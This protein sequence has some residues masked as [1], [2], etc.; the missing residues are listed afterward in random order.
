MFSKVFGSYL[1]SRRVIS[2]KD[3]YKSLEKTGN[4]R[5]KLGV[6]AVS[7]KMMTQE[8]A[9]EVNMEQ[10]VVDKRFGDIAVSK[11][12][13]TDMQVLSLLNMQ[14]DSYLDLIQNLQNN[15]ALSVEDSSRYLD[16][17]CNEYGVTPSEL[18][19]MRSGEIELIVKV[20]S[21]VNVKRVPLDLLKISGL[22]LRTVVRL[23]DSNAFVKTVMLQDEMKYNTCVSQKIDIINKKNNKNS[24]YSI[25]IADCGGN[26]LPFSRVYGE[27]EF[28]EVDMDSLDAIGEFLNCV[29]G[30]HVRSLDK[31]CEMFPPEYKLSSGVLEGTENKSIVLRVSVLGNE[32]DT[33]ISM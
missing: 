5:I 24:G 19:E 16:E 30:I 10:S 3:F 7:E 14:S 4:E 26:T 18:Q 8:Q 25:S 29:N 2:S 32:F 15:M 28:E 9:N 23:V 1:V 31:N 11:G 33:M 22:F 21:R 6:L 12:Y 20:L 13:L 17:F 27:E